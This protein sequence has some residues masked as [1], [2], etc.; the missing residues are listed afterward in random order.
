MSACTVNVI[1]DIEDD[2]WEG[3]DSVTV[4]RLEK[5]LTGQSLRQ[6]AVAGCRFI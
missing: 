6:V 5:G 1:F 3:L 2:V 4:V